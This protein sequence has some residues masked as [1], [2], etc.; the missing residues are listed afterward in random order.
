MVGIFLE[1]LPHQL[2]DL[3]AAWN[4]AALDRVAGAAHSLKGSL[5]TLSAGPGSELAERLE[6]SARS[7]D[8]EAVRSLLPEFERELEAL[9]RE[10]RAFS[11]S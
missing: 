9:C 10:L 11:L 7:Q 8:A 1:T 2:S 5:L 6:K 3:K 4:D